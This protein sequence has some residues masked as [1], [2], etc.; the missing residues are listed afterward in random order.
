MRSILPNVAIKH[1]NR[2]AT[3]NGSLNLIS[4]LSKPFTI[5]NNLRQCRCRTIYISMYMHMYIHILH[6]YAGRST[7]HIKADLTEKGDLGIVAEVSYC[8]ALITC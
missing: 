1:S 8:H 2:A 6:M 4:I 3:F 7:Q 5:D